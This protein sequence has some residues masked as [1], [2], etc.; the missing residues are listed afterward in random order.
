MQGLK[1]KSDADLY[2]LKCQLAAQMNLPGISGRDWGIAS[3][4]FLAVTEELN[5]RISKMFEE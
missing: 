2:A 3:R 5:L 4:R 1:E